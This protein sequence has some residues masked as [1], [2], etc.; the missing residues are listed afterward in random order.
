MSYSVAKLI[1]IAFVYLI[2]NE[3]FKDVE[4][5]EGP[6]ARE[7]ITAYMNRRVQE[8]RSQYK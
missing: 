6:Q 5:P 4:F 2:N 7:I 1:E 3:L 8:I